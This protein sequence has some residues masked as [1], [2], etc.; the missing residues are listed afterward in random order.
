MAFQSMVSGAECS[1]GASPLAS[2]MKQQNNDNSLHQSSFQQQGG[3]TQSIRTRNG[4]PMGQ[5]EEAERFFQ[6]NNGGGGGGS[7]QANYSMEAMRRELENTQRDGA[8][9]GDR[10]KFDLDEI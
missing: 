2:L 4:T 3:S 9:K 6:M 5:N 10:G 8:L 1:T 7:G